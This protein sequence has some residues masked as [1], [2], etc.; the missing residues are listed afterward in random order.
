MGVDAA[1]ALTRND[2]KVN[3][4]CY[5]FGFENFASGLYNSFEVDFIVGF[6]EKVHANR[7]AQIEQ[8]I[9]FFWQNR[10]DHTQRLT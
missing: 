3:T 10:I 8:M 6:R 7:N 2:R 1:I 9:S 5:N 4:M